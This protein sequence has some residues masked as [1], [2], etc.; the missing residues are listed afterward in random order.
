MYKKIYNIEVLRKQLNC[1]SY[2]ELEKLGYDVREYF[3]NHRNMQNDLVELIFIN[4]YI[5]KMLLPSSSEDRYFTEH[6]NFKS[7]LVGH[8]FVNEYI[9]RI[10]PIK[11]LI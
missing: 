4:E 3:L 11:V 10:S 1:D 5:E 8:M 7:D 2:Q 6:K 9:Q